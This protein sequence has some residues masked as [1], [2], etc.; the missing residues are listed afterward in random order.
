M[1]WTSPRTWV[2]GETVTA[3]LLNAHLRDNLLAAS[4]WED[5]TPT[6]SGAS[7]NP[8]IGN[9]SITGRYLHIGDRVDF[10]IGITMGSTTTYG[11]GLWSLTMPVTP[12]SG[13]RWM[14]TGL[15]YDLSLGDN[16]K[17]GAVADGSMEMN[18]RRDSNTAGAALATVTATNPFT[19]ANG[20]ELYLSGTYEAA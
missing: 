20:D 11:S 9:G 18:I 10:Y 17:L 13:I 19:W 15:L 8:A 4:I 14:F 12:V 16:Y 2:A 1:A 6:W 5:Y 3:A 7:G